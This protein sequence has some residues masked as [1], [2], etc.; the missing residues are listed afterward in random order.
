METMKYVIH[1]G[2][3]S[4]IMSIILKIFKE[5]RYPGRY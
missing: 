4:Q 5:I 3:M 1:L 2:L